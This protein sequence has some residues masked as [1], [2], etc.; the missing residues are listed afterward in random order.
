MPEECVVDTNV[1][2]KANQPITTEPARHSM[3]RKRLNLLDGIA[4]GSLI[5]LISRKLHAEYSRQVPEPRNEFVRAFLELITGA[6]E[7]V[8]N[9]KK[10]W[11]G[12]N[13]SG[14]RG[15]RFPKEDDHV[16]RT[17]IRPQT[18]TIFTEEKR[19][20]RVDACI[21]REFRVRIKSP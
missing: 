2:Q 6:P 19:M 10:S 12:A 17:A 16:L 5:L 13:R 14:A 18:S 7:C 8:W 1:L 9:W 3:F 15:C 11:S 20:L 21:Y 4:T